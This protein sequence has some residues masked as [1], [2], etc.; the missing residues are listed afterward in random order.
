MIQLIPVLDI[1]QATVVRGIAGERE[2]YRSNISRIVNSSDP[3]ATAN[4]LRDQFKIQMLYVADLDAL[5]KLPANEEVIESLL[6]AGFEVTLDAGIIDTETALRWIECGVSRVVVPLESLLS[7]APLSSISAAIGA[8]RILFSLDMKNGQLLGQLGQ[9]YTP[10]Q[11]LNEVAAAGIQQI[12]VLDLA[13]VGVSQG[14]FPLELCTK[15]LRDYPQFTIWSGGG[16][17]SIGDLEELQR[18]G[19]AGALVASA[20]HDAAITAADWNRFIKA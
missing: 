19:V 15:I 11:I 1:Q 14:V 9:D 7:L 3:L 17:R 6:R 16:V 12:I 18:A 8:D 2:K 10:W 20:L 5:Q 4:A 13:G